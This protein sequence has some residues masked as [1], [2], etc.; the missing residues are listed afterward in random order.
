MTTLQAISG[1]GYP[2]VA[3]WDILG[4]VVPLISGEE[5]KFQPETQKILG[6]FANGAVESHPVV[7]SAT[8]TRDNA[9]G[10]STRNQIAPSPTCAKRSSSLRS[11]SYGEASRSWRKPF[12][13]IK[14]VS[15]QHASSRS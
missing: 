13:T 9:C 15:N 7:V 6:R 3:S 1:A 5:D 14:A 2:G 12:P 10:W 11:N 8:A 4:N